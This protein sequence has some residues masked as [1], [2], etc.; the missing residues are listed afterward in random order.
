MARSAIFQVLIFQDE[1]N[2]REALERLRGPN[3]PFCLH[4]GNSDRDKITKVE[5]KK[6][7]HGPDCITAMSARVLSS[8]RLTPCSSG[9]KFR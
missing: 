7:S 9:R 2:A 5:S 3:G 6:Q 4:C 8:S 1:G